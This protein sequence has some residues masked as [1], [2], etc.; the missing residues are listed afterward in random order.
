M[1]AVCLFVQSLQLQ[2]GYEPMPVGQI[3]QF[4][5]YALD[6]IGIFAFALTGAFMAVRKDFD[7]FGTFI[8]A[9]VAGLGGG[10]LRDL[11]IGV[12]PVAFTDVGFYLT[13]LLA[14]VIVFFGTTLQRHERVCDVFDAAALG[15]FSVSGTI[16]ALAHG[17]GL[18]SAAA[19]GIAT[20]VGGGACSN[21]LAREVPPL[22]RW[23]QNLYTLPALVG[24]GTVAAL[25]SAGTLSPVT[26]VC[27]T[28]PA[29]AIRLLALRYGWRTPRSRAWR[30]VGR[31]R[32]AEPA[33]AE[34]GVPISLQV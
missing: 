21:V 22:L 15:L 18:G 9:E 20:A 26:T 25:H 24:A 10:L 31:H 27:A 29:F 13:P 17:F 32:V 2:Q 23:D 28:V 1:L 4:V 14:A 33:P 30:S 11:V 5:R 16:K 3:I 7:I 12:R 19:L 6:L 8:M 34:P